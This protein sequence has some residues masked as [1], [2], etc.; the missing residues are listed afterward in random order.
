[1]VSEIAKRPLGKTNLMIT[2]LGFGG[3]AVGNLYSA[4]DPAD[5]LAA[6][7]AAWTFG[8]NYYDTAPFYGYGL[9]ERRIGDFLRDKPR[10]RFVLSGKVGRLLKPRLDSISG[11][12]PFPGSPPFKPIFDYTYDGVMRSFEDS[13]QRL[14]L[15]RIDVLYIHD[16]GVSTHGPNK[17]PEMMKICME[18]GYKALAKL[19]QEQIIGAIGI[20]V[21]DWQ[22]C[23]EAM[24]QADFDCFLLAGRYTLLEQTAV[25]RFLPECERRGV[26]VIIGGPYNSGILATGAHPEARYNYQ[27]APPDILQ[28]VKNIENICQRYG[29]S[30]AAAALQFPLAHPAVASV[31]P[32]ARSRAEVE[33]NMALFHAPIPSDFWAELKSQGLLRGDAPTPVS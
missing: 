27:P 19:R 23:L 30:L 28:K 25:E 8:I 11:F 3:A 24:N 10:E 26:S 32:G 31:I 12:N 13:L 14:G 5:A 21:N 9:S 22:V 17:Q 7:D 15:N 20:G 1:M 4:V 6:L 2:T 16:I 29:V 33:Q 18:S